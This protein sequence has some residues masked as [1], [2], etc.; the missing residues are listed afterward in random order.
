MGN[1]LQSNRIE[2]YTAAILDSLREFSPNLPQHDWEDGFRIW[3]ISNSYTRKMGDDKSLDKYKYAKITLEEIKAGQG[4]LV[5]KENF[6]I[7]EK[8]KKENMLAGAKVIYS[9]WSGYL[10]DNGFWEDNAV[11]LSIIHCSGHAYTKDLIRLVKSANPKKVIPNHTFYPDQFV[12][13]FGDKAMLLDDGET[14]GC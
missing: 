11:P 7:R 13:L 4:M 8:L 3:F 12:D 6:A 5:I 1:A 14:I 9:M 10:K 2:L